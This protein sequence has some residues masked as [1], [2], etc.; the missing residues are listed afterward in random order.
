MV[1]KHLPHKILVN[2]QEKKISFTENHFNQ[3]TQVPTPVMRHINM[4]LLRSQT[5]TGI[6]QH[7]VC[8]CHKCIT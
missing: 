5:K 3:V 4:Y 8:G 2:Y 6:T 7:N 1:S